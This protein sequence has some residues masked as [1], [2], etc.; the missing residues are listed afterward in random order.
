[1]AATLSGTYT[2]APDTPSPVF[3]DRLIRPLPKRPIRSRISPEVAE[4]I[5]YPPAP[6][7]TQLFYGA[8]AGNG[9]VNDAKVYVQRNS[10][11][12]EPNP[13]DHHIYEDGVDSDED[14]P[15]VVRRSA[16]L[17]RSSLPHSEY[18][19]HMGTPS[20]SSSNSLD[21]YDAF[22]N[23]NNKKKRKIPTSGSL[24]CHSIS[25]DI[26]NMSPSS[27]NGTSTGILEDNSATGS[28]YGSGNPVSPAGSG[29]SGSGRGRFGRNAARSAAGRVPLANYSSNW[30]GNRPPG[31]RREPSHLG[32]E[33]TGIA[34]FF[35]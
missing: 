13:D 2:S 19:K 3:P 28:Y 1:M 5:L 15:V 11:G 6:P 4:S 20:K 8:Y 30:L 23:T 27:P 34:P 12:F 35:L 25:A 33:Q 14:G 17:D 32:Q 21:G 10:Y 29:I 16:G 31:S 9:D 7:V 18:V 26:L 22:E 24:G